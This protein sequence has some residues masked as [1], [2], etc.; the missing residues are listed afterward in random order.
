MGPVEVLNI[1][2]SWENLI[3]ERANL[4]VEPRFRMTSPSFLEFAASAIGG[5]R[6]IVG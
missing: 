6:G 2:D 4:R 3:G 5:G 1:V